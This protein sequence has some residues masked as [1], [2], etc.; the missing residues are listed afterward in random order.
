M[1]SCK[2]KGFEKQHCS[3]QPS[4]FDF[5]FD[6]DDIVYNKTIP[7]TAEKTILQ[8]TKHAKEQKIGPAYFGS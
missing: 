6:F 2:F 8:N 4:P 7:L 1:S 3:N 5:D